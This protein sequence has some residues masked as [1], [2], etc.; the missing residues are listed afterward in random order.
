MH[1]SRF[2]TRFVFGPPD[3][4]DQIGH[5]RALPLKDHVFGQIQAVGGG[6]RCVPIQETQAEKLGTLPCGAC[7]QDVQRL[8]QD[9]FDGQVKAGH[10]G[11][12]QPLGNDEHVTPRMLLLLTG[13][14]LAKRRVNSSRQL[15]A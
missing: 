8:K 10:R 14:P 12:S 9:L 15:L 4:A 2:G 6:H 1:I 5:G 3:D 11:F 7:F 13:V